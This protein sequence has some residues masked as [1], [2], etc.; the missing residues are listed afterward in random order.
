MVAIGKALRQ[1]SACLRR[2]AKCWQ[3][4][5]VDGQ[6]LRTEYYRTRAALAYV[7][8]SHQ[9]P[10]G[11]TLPLERREALLAWARNCG[12]YVLEDDYDSDFFYDRAPLLAL[13]WITMTR[14]C[15]WALSPRPM[16]RA[17]ALATWCCCQSVPGGSERQGHAEQQPV[18]AGAG[19]AGS[20]HGRGWL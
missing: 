19:G 14:W 3:A 1:A 10:L 8:P 9:Y 7:T 17:C 13:A 15:T 5:P 11:G 6:T 16:A 4:Y 20:L 18:L 2:M 12:A